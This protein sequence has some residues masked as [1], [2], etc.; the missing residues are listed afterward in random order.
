MFVNKGKD[1]AD[2]TGH[3]HMFKDDTATLWMRASRTGTYCR[4]IGKETYAFEY[5]DTKGEWQY[6][7]GK[8]VTRE[9]RRA[10]R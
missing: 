4:T 5:T 7:V 2:I 10:R 1:G 3:F 6:I 9:S 8:K